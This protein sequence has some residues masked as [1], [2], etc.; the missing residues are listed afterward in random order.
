MCFNPLFML[1][2]NLSVNSG[3]LVIKVWE[4]TSYMWVFN[5]AGADGQRPSSPWC[6]MVNRGTFHP[7]R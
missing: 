1:L 7:H 3:L 4:V 2:V 6:S 5:G